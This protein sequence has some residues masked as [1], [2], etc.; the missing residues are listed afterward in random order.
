MI[1]FGSPSP[2]ME[3]VGV[4][5]AHVSGRDTLYMSANCLS[6][7]NYFPFSFDIRCSIFDICI[8]HAF[9]LTN[10]INHSSDKLTF[11]KYKI[12]TVSLEIIPIILLSFDITYILVC[13]ISHPS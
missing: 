1:G 11:H 6:T 7:F 8:Y 2:S 10:H 3:R 12:K 4:R 5:L 9:N 13:Q